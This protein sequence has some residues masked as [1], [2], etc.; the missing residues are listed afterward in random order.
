MKDMMSTIASI[1]VLMIFLMQFTVNQTTYTRVMG[2]E[3][4]V[5]GFRQT[6]E[7]TQEI[8]DSAV[9]DLKLKLAAALRCGAQEVTTEVSD[10]GTYRVSAPVRGV[11]GAAS[12]LGI[13]PEENFFIYRTEGRIVLR[14]EEPDDH[15]G[16]GTP[17]EH[18]P[19]IPDG[20]ERED[21]EKP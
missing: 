2:A 17:D 6:A 7:S 3:Y 9:Q 11:I 20:T 15:P 8:D 1:L 12:A 13:R 19:A 16:T 10:N 5:R 14:N 18:A 21:L 4:A